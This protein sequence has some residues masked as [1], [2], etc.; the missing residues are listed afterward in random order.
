MQTA[1]NKEETTYT[2]L[3]DLSADLPPLFRGLAGRQLFVL[4][5]S[6]SRRHCLP[7]VRNFLPEG[8]EV[9]SIVAGEANKTLA[10]CSKV[11]DTLT[12]KQADR[13]AVLLVLG[14][15]MPG[16]LG[17]FCAA[18]YKRGIACIQMPTTLL[19]MADAGV[20]GKNGIDFQSFKNQIGTFRQ[21]NAVW[22]Y[23]PFLQS[24]P[25]KELLSGFAEIVKHSLIASAPTWQALRKK[26]LHRQDWG[27]LITSSIAAKQAIVAADFEE[28]GERKKLN[29]GHTAGHAIESYFL[30]RQQPV[31]HG[32]CVAAGLV[33][34]GYIAM[35]HGLLSETELVQVE[36][37]IYTLYGILPV[38]ARQIRQIWKQALHDKKNATGEVRMALYGP[39]GA[40]QVNV[41]V[42]QASFEEAMRYYLGLIK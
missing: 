9:I 34:E 19:A 40:C 23:P 24:L 38:A 7:L 37:L 20:G 31:P 42:T 26:E 25:E 14:G 35:K 1:D 5:D 33:V 32:Y 28:T 39:I 21:P 8:A 15:G 16:D 10:T 3:S 4:V 11:W 36:E 41:P 6:G 13:Q 18:T 2:I 30:A 12:R 29:A 17:A 22:L 27:A